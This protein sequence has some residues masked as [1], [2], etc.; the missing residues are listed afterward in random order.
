LGNRLFK[1]GNYAGASWSYRQGANALKKLNANNAHNEQVRSILIA[2]QTKLS[3]VVH[4][5]RKY[6]MSRDVASRV[7]GINPGCIKALYCHAMAH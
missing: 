7:L 2:L 4:K 6:R 1:S 5:Q 3:T